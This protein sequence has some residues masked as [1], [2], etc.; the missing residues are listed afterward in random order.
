MSSA[1]L[2]TLLEKYGFVRN[3]GLKAA[4][5]L[6]CLLPRHDATGGA[7][8]NR[9]LS[10]EARVHRQFAVAAR[11]SP[12][13][14]QA[15]SS[16]ATALP[17]IR[18][19]STFDGLKTM[20]RR[21]VIGTSIPVLGFRPIRSDLERT[22]NRPNEDNLT[23][24]PPIK[25]SAS[26]SNTDCTKIPDSLRER[27]T[28]RYTASAKS[29]RVTVRG[30]VRRGPSP[31]SSA[32]DNPSSSAARIVSD[33]GIFNPVN[34]FQS[35]GIELIRQ[36]PTWL[37][38]TK[39]TNTSGVQQEFFNSIRRQG[40]FELRVHAKSMDVVTALRAC[41]PLVRPAAEG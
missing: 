30:A 39:E 9:T 5:F 27:P 14:A 7:R 24:S 2:R 13:N 11:T 6:C 28:Q 26:S 16:S 29:T 15:S 37:R 31:L 34:L 38:P 35:C 12:E 8:H 25:A 18:A 22:K 17:L 3:R 23:D 4:V 41:G 21:S 1:K 40:S 32:A 20:T 36:Q 10:S 33:F 19:L